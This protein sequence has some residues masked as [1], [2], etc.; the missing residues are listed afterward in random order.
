MVLTLRPVT[1]SVPQGLVL[2]LVLFGIFIN[3]LD[4]GIESLSKFADDAKM[5]G[6]TYTPEGCATILQ[7]L[8]RRES[9]AERNLTRSNKS[10]GRVLHLGIN[11]CMHQCR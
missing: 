11:E 10:K 8:N 3:N 6:E 5:G 9:W 1:S 7:G 2:G 4:E